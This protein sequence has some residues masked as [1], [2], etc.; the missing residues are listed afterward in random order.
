MLFAPA[1]CRKRFAR[2]IPLSDAMLSRQRGELQSAGVAA[3]RVPRGS[4]SMRPRIRAG[5]MGHSPRVPTHERLERAF[6]G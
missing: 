4:A 3:V 6:V 2:E 1:E 5:A